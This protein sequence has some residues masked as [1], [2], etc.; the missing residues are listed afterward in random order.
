[1]LK[2]NDRKYN[3]YDIKVKWGNFSAYSNGT[4]TSGTAPF[5]TFNIKNSIFVGLEFI[6]SKEMFEN[7]ELNTVINIDKYISDITYEDE[8]GWASFITEKYNCNMTRI[9][10]NIFKIEFYIE[11]EEM[12]I[13]IGTNIEL[14]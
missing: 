13:I 8:K 1:M 2:I 3:D 5:I 11:S 12:N 9:N 14:L 7:T 6:F 10:E 4:K